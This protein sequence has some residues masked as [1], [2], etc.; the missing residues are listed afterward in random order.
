VAAQRVAIAFE[1]SFLFS[2]TVEATSPTAAGA[3]PAEI[4]AAARA[5]AAHEFILELPD[6]YATGSATW[7]DAI[8][9]TTPTLALARAILATRRCSSS[10]TPPAP[11][12]PVPAGDPRRTALRAGR[13][14][15]ILIAHRLFDPRLADRI[16]VVED[17]RVV[18]DGTHEELTEGSARYRSLLS[19][20]T[21][22]D[23]RRI[24]R[25]RTGRSV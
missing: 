4:E 6:G 17:G 2:D 3:S 1:D 25:G 5:A 22:A 8:R 23:P 21:T 16:V 13:R 10:T 18:E 7:P 11:W 14:T 9:R 15:T 24:H 19:V 20:W 12:I